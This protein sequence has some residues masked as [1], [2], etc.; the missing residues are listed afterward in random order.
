[1][2]I[3]NAGAI[4]PLIHVLETGSPEAKE[5]SAATLFSLSVMEENK[6]RIGRSGAIGPL[7]ELLGNGT[8]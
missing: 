7:V 2:A 8:P 1:M 6:S 5:N 4:E 3:A